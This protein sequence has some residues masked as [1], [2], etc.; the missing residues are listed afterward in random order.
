MIPVIIKFNQLKGLIYLNQNL[1]HNSIY[2][3]TNGSVFDMV[4]DNN[5]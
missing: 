3:Y 4:L 1:Y 5:D 2:E